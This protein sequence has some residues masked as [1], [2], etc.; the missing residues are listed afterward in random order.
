[1]Q[2]ARAAA[3]AFV[4][5][6]ATHRRRAAL[7]MAIQHLCMTCIFKSWRRGISIVSSILA[8]GG[9]MVAEWRSKPGKYG[10]NKGDRPRAAR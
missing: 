3:P 10:R 9:R 5:F 4:R 1:M 7:Y 2:L 6:C 8:P